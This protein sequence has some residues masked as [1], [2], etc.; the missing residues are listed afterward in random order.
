[1][2]SWSYS[3]TQVKVSS[4]IVIPRR[5][6]DLEESSSEVLSEVC[7]LDLGKVPHGKENCLK[8]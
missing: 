8:G 5:Y 4:E 7:W 3:A 1:M 2:L 6:F